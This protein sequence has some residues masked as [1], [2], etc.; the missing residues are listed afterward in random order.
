MFTHKCHTNRNIRA[1]F[2]RGNTDL[3]QPFI[4]LAG[5]NDYEIIILSEETLKSKEVSPAQE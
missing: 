4:P 3:S 5:L 2:S 1:T